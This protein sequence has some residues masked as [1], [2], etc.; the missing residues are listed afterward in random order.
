MRKKLLALLLSLVC[1]LTLFGAPAAAR[2]VEEP[3]A[4]AAPT[5]EPTEEPTPTPVPEP[6]PEPSPEPEP[7]PTPEPTPEP[8]P[9]GPW[10]TEAMAFAVDNHI[11]VG[12]E[13]GN[14]NPTKKRHPCGDG[15][16]ARAHFRLHA[17]Q[18]PCAFSGCEPAAVV[19]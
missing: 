10:Y 17:G 7:T 8:T 2:A 3:A 15:D 1:V 5:A 14:L 4:T 16:D 9:A 6:T 13:Y 18:E 12:D 11:L 19:C